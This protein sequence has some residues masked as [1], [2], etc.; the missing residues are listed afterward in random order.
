M[1]LPIYKT[2][3]EKNEFFESIVIQ[4]INSLLGKL[5]ELKKRG[6]YF[7]GQANASWKL[8]SSA[9]RKWVENMPSE[10]FS[11]F[12][13]FVKQHIAFQLKHAKSSYDQNCKQQND[14]SVLSVMQHFGAPTPFIDF[15]S[16]PDVAIF[17]ATKPAQI[18]ANN[19]SEKYVSIYAWQP[20]N[21]P[22]TGVYN[23]L[24]NW[25][26]IVDT[27]DGDAACFSFAT[28]EG[29][30][31]IYIKED[32]NRYMSIA[33]PRLDLQNGLFLFVGRGQ[34]LLEPCEVFF[35]GVSAFDVAT[36]RT[37][38]LLP[39]I[40]CF[41]IHKSLLPELHSYL[42][43]KGVTKSSLGLDNDYWAEKIYKDFC[44]SKAR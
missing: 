18:V 6:F 5:S 4:D 41:N 1:P 11:S 3:S 7:R 31:A 21:G 10:K 43:T 30:T 13:G 26:S 40:M 38:I 27:H 29:L 28:F 25:E 32:S 19:E 22:A 12:T 8:Y 15:T 23:D 20:G 24:T 34:N 37:T 9:Q 35:D 33:N 39:K 44:D 2:L 17:F 14:I 36:N 42:N 16:S